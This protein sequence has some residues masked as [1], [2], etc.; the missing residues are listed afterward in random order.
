MTK[1]AYNALALRVTTIVAAMLLVLLPAT[2]F[3]SF[4]SVANATEASSV[5]SLSTFTIDGQA[6]TDGAT[7]SAPYGTDSVE[8]V[9]PLQ[10]LLTVQLLTLLA[11]L[12]WYPDQTLLP[13]LLQ[14]KMM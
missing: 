6:V 13:P 5:T 2:G 4:A 1:N 12:I 10:L 7:V 3:G 14:Q 8:V 11:T 9:L